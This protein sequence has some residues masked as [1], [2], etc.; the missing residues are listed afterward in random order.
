MDMRRWVGILCV[1]GLTACA[2]AAPAAGAPVWTA[3]SVLSSPRERAS[4]PAVAVSAGGRM[5]AAWVVVRGE[6]ETREGQ[7]EGVF[8]GYGR[9][10]ARLGTAARGW[11][12]T[13]VL[14]SE[15]ESP[16]AAV[17]ANGTAA[18]AWCR[19]P[20]SDVRMLYVSIASP[21]RAFGPATLLRTGG[22]FPV[23]CP[24][25]LKVQP[26][27]RVV[28]IWSQTLEYEL[29]PI[30]S[31]VQF[32]LLR[33]HGGR[34][35]IGTVSADVPGEVNVDAAETEGGDVLVA[36]AVPTRLR[37]AQGVAQLHPG[38]SRFTA[39][40]A[41]EAAGNAIVRTES[42]SAGPGGAAL[43]FTV[44]GE[45]ADEYTD[46]NAMAEQEPNGAF[47]PPVVIFRQPDLR[48]GDQF[49]PDGANVAFPAGGARV[50]TWL[51]AFIG[52]PT[53]GPVEL[54]GEVVGPE[55]V[56]A[57]VRPA[58]ATGFQA[59]VRLSVGAGRSG[60]P[61]ISSAGAGAVV[62]WAQDEP[63]CRQ[64]IY[65]AVGAVGT[66][67]AQVLPVSGRY[68]PARGECAEGS[69]QLVL[70]GS[71]AGAIA[72]WVQNSTLHITTTVD[73]GSG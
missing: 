49:R 41:I 37:Q 45:F 62:L 61:V 10:E 52:P 48:S 47:G 6:A 63:G 54:E 22:R 70:A 68:Q 13:Q 7:P 56:M 27:G 65:S 53:S 38:A 18:V 19:S 35:V 15:G 21:G 72:G 2:N 33:A 32:A 25:A 51:N 3:S 23:N 58:G 17:G 64:R 69:G 55:V 8:T 71:S 46:E 40:Q 66:A 31:R 39:P 26:D 20:K 28:L 34:P 5:L 44:G 73:G 60:T 30:K 14:S 1:A 36:F 50:A 11:R 24:E 4:E 59:P 9:I 43:A 16:I 42:V 12:G 57:A 67:S 29:T